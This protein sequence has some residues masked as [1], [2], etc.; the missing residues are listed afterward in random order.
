MSIMSKNQK[1]VKRQPQ[2][3]M[4][5]RGNPSKPGEKP[6]KARTASEVPDPDLRLRYPM[7]LTAGLIGR[8][9]AA[10]YYTP[11]LTVASLAEAAF[12]AELSKMEKQRGMAF[13]PLQ[14]KLKAG[15]PLG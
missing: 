8:I 10:V 14:M 3:A 9:R 2:N 12:T 15:R 7:Q 6:R 11:G 5:K 13:L 1:A 4:P